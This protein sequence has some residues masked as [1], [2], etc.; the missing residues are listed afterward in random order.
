MLFTYNAKQRLFEKRTIPFKYEINH[1]FYGLHTTKVSNPLSGNAI[2][3]EECKESKNLQ[4][5]AKIYATL[6]GN[7]AW[8]DTWKKVNEVAAFFTRNEW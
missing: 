2:Q 4:G 5:E 3:N 7:Q 8:S 6:R 1:V